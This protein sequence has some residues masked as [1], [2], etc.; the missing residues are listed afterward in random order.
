MKFVY[1]F[2]FILFL[3]QQVIGQS[4]MLYTVGFV[5]SNSSISVSSSSYIL[6][7]KN[8]I[9][10]SNGLSTFMPIAEGVYDDNC[11][12]KMDF[13]KVAV[14]IQPNPIDHYTIIKFSASKTTDNVIK[15]KLYNEIGKLIQVNEVLQSNFIGNGYK[16]IVP[17]YAS[18]V[19]YLNISA[20]HL[21]ESHKLFKL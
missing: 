16:Y 14:N 11:I 6:S 12:I 1:T 8:C 17:D 15:L 10:I 2:I 7:A 13:S 21:N 3:S 20:D 18:G 5:T 19:Y 4:P 9:T